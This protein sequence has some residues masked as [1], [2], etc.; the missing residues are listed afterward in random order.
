MGCVA[1]GVGSNL[2]SPKLLRQQNW[3]EITRLAKEFVAVVRKFK[4]AE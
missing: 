2:V 3:A 1:L 4:A